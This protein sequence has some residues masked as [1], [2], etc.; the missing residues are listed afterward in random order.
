MYQSD[1]APSV[2]SYILAYHDLPNC[3]L[4]NTGV[5]WTR[6]V[7]LFVRL[8]FLDGYKLS[9]RSL[10]R[11][12]R[13]DDCLVNASIGTRSQKAEDVVLLQHAYSSSITPRPVQAHRRRR[14][15]GETHV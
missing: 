5:D 15:G 6:R 11:L 12:C 2:V 14:S 13:L 3:T 8:E 9:S 1:E 10:R 7:I 4:R